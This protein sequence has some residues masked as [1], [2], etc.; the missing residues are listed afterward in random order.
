MPEKI[1]ESELIEELEKIFDS[2]LQERLKKLKNVPVSPITFILFTRI[3]ELSAIINKH[4]EPTEESLEYLFGLRNKLSRMFLNTLKDIFFG[5]YFTDFD[6]TAYLEDMVYV[7][8]RVEKIQSEI[9]KLILRGVKSGN[10]VELYQ[11]LIKFLL[12]MAWFEGSFKSFV[13]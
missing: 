11:C 9:D 5:L 1:Q 8:Q 12:N 10:L 13:R 2:E 7:L 4:I 3:A 6:K